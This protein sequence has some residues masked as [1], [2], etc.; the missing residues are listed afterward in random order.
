MPSISIEQ[1]QTQL[2]DLV[3]H[4]AP[5]DEW[6]ITYQDRPVARLISAAEKVPRARR[7]GSAIGKMKILAEDDE[8]LKDFK[9]YMP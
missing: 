1:A 4:L 9:D 3:A 5:G 7:P 6:L 2:A 8:H